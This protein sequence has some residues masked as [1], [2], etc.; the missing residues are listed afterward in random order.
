MEILTFVFWILLGII[1]VAEIILLGFIFINAVLA[2]KD[3]NDAKS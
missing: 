2:W 3:H 1:C